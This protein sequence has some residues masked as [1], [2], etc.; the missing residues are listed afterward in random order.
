[1]LLPEQL[2][3]R[4]DVSRFSQLTVRMSDFN[5]APPLSANYQVP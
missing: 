5:A 1:M 2:P 3:A 4:T